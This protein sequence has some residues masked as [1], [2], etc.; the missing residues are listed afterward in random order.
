M[1][2]IHYNPSGKFQVRDARSLLD[3]L[4]AHATGHYVYVLCYPS[5]SNNFRPFYV[6]IGQGK[7]IF[8]HERDAKNSSLSSPK[9]RV[10]RDILARGDEV[11]RFLD[12]IFQEEPW[13]REQELITQFGLL[14]D[15]TGILFNEQRYSPSSLDNGVELRKYASDGNDLPKNFIRKD[16]RLIVGL[17]KPKKSSSVYGIIYATLEKN[18]GVTGAELV[19]LLL[20]L[21]FSKNKT[22]YAQSGQVSRPWLAKYIDGGFYAKNLYIREAPEKLQSCE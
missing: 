13:Q 4:S 19:E 15:G 12:G 18:P 3:H 9:L 6:G 17:Q 1:A 10:I 5:S 22:V 11:V 21:D 16:T 20:S 14:K 2:T 7:R 8:S